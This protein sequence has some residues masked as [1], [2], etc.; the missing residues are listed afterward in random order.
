MNYVFAAVTDSESAPAALV[1]VWIMLVGMFLPI[2]VIVKCCIKKNIDI[3]E[4]FYGKN[5]VYEK[6]A[7]YFYEDYDRENPVTHEEGVAA[8]KRLLK[9]H[10]TEDAQAILNTAFPAQAN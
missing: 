9:Q 1:V 10:G 7:I 3:Y 5:D 2:G 8:Y 4:K 6:Q